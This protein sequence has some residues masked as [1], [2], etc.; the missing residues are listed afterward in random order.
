VFHSTQLSKFAAVA[1]LACALP[2][3]AAKPVAVDKI[4]VAQASLARAEQA[5]AGQF[6]QIE[7]KSAR[8]KLAAAETASDKRKKE[9]ATRLAEEADLEAQLAESTARAK[10]QEQLVAQ[11][12]AGL[13]DLRNEATRNRP[14]Q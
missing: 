9:V 12:E 14:A 13:R 2:C 4:A 1:L 6:A 7:L 3:A 10:Q 8:D 11:M 5:Q